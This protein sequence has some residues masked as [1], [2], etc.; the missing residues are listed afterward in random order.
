MEVKHPSRCESSGRAG[1]KD[2]VS[3]GMPQR[4]E[5]MFENIPS[6]LQKPIFNL[7]NNWDWLG[8]KI[9]ALAINSTVNVC[10]HRPH[11]WSTA[12]DYVSWTSLSDRRWSARHLPAEY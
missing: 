2:V 4:G 8:G 6:W 10:R 1:H 11:P 9:N 12:H 7:A 3:R 5:V